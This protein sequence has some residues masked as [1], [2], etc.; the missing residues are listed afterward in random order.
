MDTNG[1]SRLDQIE[2]ELRE[3]VRVIGQL[4]NH[5]KLQ[6]DFMAKLAQGELM[7][8]EDLK[9]VDQELKRAAEVRRRTEEILEQISLNLRESSEK[10]DALIQVV[11]DL[12]RKQPRPEA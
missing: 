11:D 2:D 7:L 5:E 10:L 8:A 4:A 9:R 1:R 12:V 6:D 3:V